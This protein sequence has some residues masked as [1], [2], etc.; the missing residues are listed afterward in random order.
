MMGDTVHPNENV[1]GGMILQ[2][3]WA[4]AGLPVVSDATELWWGS[5]AECRMGSGLQ[6]IVQQ[7]DGF[8]GYVF[9]GPHQRITNARMVLKM[10]VMA[11]SPGTF[12]FRVLLTAQ[13][14]SRGSICT[15]NYSLVQGTYT[16]TSKGWTPVQLPVD[17]TGYA[18]C[19]LGVQ[20]DH[21]S[22][23]NTLEIGYFN[24]V[25]FTGQLYIP[26]GTHTV[27]APCPVAGEI[28]LDSAHLWTCSPASGTTFGPGTWQ[29]H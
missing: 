24:F 7:F 10:N 4:E 15:P 6:C 1:L 5:H 20:F 28:S 11:K 9:I 19:T 23:S 22:A 8:N 17:F 21:G 2:G 25:P 16:A 29:Q 12:N 26:L 13:S 14:P 3:E 18:G 27:G